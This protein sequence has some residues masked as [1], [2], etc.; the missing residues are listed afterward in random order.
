M[1]ELLI[2]ILITVLV[3]LIT[4][5]WTINASKE[6][7]FVGVDVNKLE[8]PKVP[9]L[10][11]I[12]ILAGFVGGNFALIVIDQKFTGIITAVLVSSLIIGFIGM[13]DDVFNLKQS[14]RAV[15][16]VFASVPLA[17]YSVGHSTISIPFIGPVNFGLLYYILII[18]AALT[19]TSNAFNMLEGLN[20]LGVGMGIIMALTLTLLGLRGKGVT[21]VSGEMALILAVS[22]LTFLYFN[23]YPAK[24]FLG[25]IGTYLI[26]SAIGAIGISGYFL[27]ALAFLF[28]PYV[29]EFILKARTK[30]KG[31][32]FGNV[33][34]DGTLSWTEY[35]NSITHVIMKMGRFK[36]YQIVAIIWGIEI[37]MAILAFIF[38]I[39]V[40]KL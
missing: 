25:N 39:T 30:F 23:K 37:I 13:L 15:T 5:R 32:S 29:I 18:P 35:P 38:Q 14:L 20:G 8:K 28:I 4:T 3:T 2:P 12:G 9:L 26:G 33:N 34:E 10:G 22:L 1:L 36:E 27:T 6:K 16:P 19:I 24:I 31:V 40:I 21:F 17:I 7:G 11:G